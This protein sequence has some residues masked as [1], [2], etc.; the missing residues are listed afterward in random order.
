MSN[1]FPHHVE[2]RAEDGFDRAKLQMVADW[3][4]EWGFDHEG[5]EIE[6][7]HIVRACFAS[8]K[9]ARTVHRYHG[10]RLI[11]ADEIEQ[12]LDAD[13]MDEKLYQRDADE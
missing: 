9:D 7:G 11:P 5:R 6:P 3:L 1:D 10:G 4:A 12:A 8:A 2:F 13:E